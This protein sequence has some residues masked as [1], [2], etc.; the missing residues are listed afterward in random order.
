MSSVDRAADYLRRWMQEIMADRE[1]NA[2]EWAKAA[3]TS[4]TNITRFVKGSDHIPSYATLLKLAAV[5]GVPIPTPGVAARDMPKIR[6][7]LLELDQIATAGATGLQQLIKQ[8]ETTIVADYH[9]P[10]AFALRLKTSAFAGL[11]YLKGDILIVDPAVTPK[12]GLH[13]LCHAN[14]RRLKIFVFDKVLSTEHGTL[15][16]VIVELI[17]SMV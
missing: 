16:G 13:V 10:G 15:C 2:E 5:A 9:R 17:R 8:A 3:Q 7:P 12:K 6:I 1:W 4:P 14:Y 11:G